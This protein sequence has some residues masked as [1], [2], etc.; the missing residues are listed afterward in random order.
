M[1]TKNNMGT[2]DRA[3]RLVIAGIVA[4]LYFTGKVSGT[5]GIVL[6]ILAVIFVATSIAGFCPLY[7]L[8]GLS[9]CKR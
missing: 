1:K 9:T 2:L 3:I 8:F 5:F 4:I 6:A 7:V